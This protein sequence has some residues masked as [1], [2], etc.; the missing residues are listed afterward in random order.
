MKKR[1]TSLTEF[2][3]R[4]RETG[5]YRTKAECRAAK[6]AKPGALT[7]LRYTLGVTHVFPACA[8][9]EPFG[10]LTTD[11]WAEFCFAA[12]RTPEKLGMNV[13]VEGFKDRLAYSGP[14]MYLANH[15]STTETIVLPP[16]LLSFGP[17]SYVAKASLAHLPFLEKAAEHMRMVPIGRKSPREDLVNI[18]KI[19]GERI[20]GGD[21][22]LIF[23]QGTRADVFSRAQ[24]SSIGA[25]LAERAG[26]PI[27]PIAVDTRCQPMRKKGIWK[28][29]FR[30]FGPVDTSKDIRIAAG[31]LIPCAKAREMHEKSFDWIA[32]KLEEWGIPTEREG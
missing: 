12:V 22:F 26:V 3:A 5:E 1:A 24:Y 20:A 31:P 18:L 16:I 10:R 15:M 4:L 32:G 28:G 19:G 7:T 27:V 2:Q 11:V 21:S 25:K 23:P 9:A 14:V 30:D 8:L 6:R 17:F 29:I 13:I